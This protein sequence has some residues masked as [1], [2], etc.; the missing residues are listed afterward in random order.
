MI[1]IKIGFAEL[2][3]AYIK[4]KLTGSKSD[5][6]PGIAATDQ[7]HQSDMIEFNNAG[8]IKSE[9]IKTLMRKIGT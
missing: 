4:S 3:F 9:L 6:V 8:S 7:Y 1:A 5:V 2:W